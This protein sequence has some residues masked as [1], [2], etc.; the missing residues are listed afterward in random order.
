MKD[1]TVENPVFSEKISIVEEEDLV[2]AEND[3]AA[4]KQLIQNDLVLSKR[5]K[6]CL[7]DAQNMGTARIWS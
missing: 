7:G 1:Y 3:T 6:Q 2:S 4:A 5:M